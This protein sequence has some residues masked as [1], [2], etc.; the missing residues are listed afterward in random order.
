MSCACCGVDTKNACVTPAVRLS[1]VRFSVS[2]ALFAFAFAASLIESQMALPIILVIAW[3]LAGYR[4]LIASVRNALRG[5]FFDENFL[6]TIATLGAFAIGEWSEGAAVMLFYNLGEILQESALTRSRKSIS[7]LM[8]VRPDR[9]R[10]LAAD[11]S[12]GEFAHP[13]D[14]PVGSLV[15]VFPGEKVPLDGVIVDGRSFFDTSR[16]T[17]ESLPRDS[18]PDSEVLAGF[19]AMNSGVTVR[20]TALFAES[21]AS[22]MLALVEGAAEKKARVE[23]LITSFARVYTPIVTF[24]ALALAVLPPLV[25]ALNSGVAPGWSAF[26]PWVYRALVF[27]VISCP[28]AF[29]LSVPLGYFGGIGGAA[30]K[31]ILV[32]GATAIDALARAGTVVFDKTGTLT[33]GTFSVTAAVPA[34]GYD[35][36][37]LVSLAAAAESESSHPIARAIVAYASESGT[38]PALGFDSIEEIGGLGVASRAGSKRILAGSRALLERAGVSVPDESRGDGGASV[39]TSV[40]VAEDDSYAGRLVLSDSVKDG[41]REAI[42]S[43]RAIGIRDIVM[44]TG[45]AEAVAASVS[46]EIGISEWVSGVLPHEKVERYEALA[47]RAARASGARTTVFVGDGI[48]DAPA[49]ARADVGIA[50]GAIGSDAACEAAD[51]VLMN[52]DPRLVTR[53]IA[54]ARHTRAIVAQNIAVS[55]IVKIGFLALGAMGLASL[56]E[57]VFADVGVALIATANSLR[58]RGLAKTVR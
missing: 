9:A 42:A 26:S 33:K 52:D 37:H 49:L 6:M 20:T 34:P 39:G 24:L 58:A 3:L 50:M 25:L 11:G 21:A 7:D 57:A 29:V 48:N 16:L 51:V 30:R 41:S 13:A 2:A 18:G 32:K 4:V 56:W 47:A 40:Y 28:C 22:R 14:V 44:L 36:A 43:L 15:R 5:K 46:R 10:L 55:F 1:V 27:L 8:D 35:E 23:R 53:A 17:G 54:H 12:A 45:D 38:A 19:V 31:G